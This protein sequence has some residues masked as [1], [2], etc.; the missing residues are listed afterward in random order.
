[1]DISNQLFKI[2]VLLAYYGPIP[3]LKKG[4]MAFVSSVEGDRVSCK[5][6]PHQCGQANISCSKQKMGMVRKEGPCIAGSLG[7]RQKRAEPINEVV[8]VRVIPE[9]LFSTFYPPDY[10]VMYGIRGIQA[11]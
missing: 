11:C 5:Q 9:D 2:Y 10:D 3:V 7:L 8:P 4:A 1:V 6:S